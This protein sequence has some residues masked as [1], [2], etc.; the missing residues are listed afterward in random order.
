MKA[1]FR[2]AVQGCAVAL[3]FASGGLARA[4]EPPHPPNGAPAPAAAAAP[5]PPGSP[6]VLPP[7]PQPKAFA[8]VIKG[9]KELPGFFKLY[10]KDEKVWIA[11]KPEQLDKPFFFSYNIPRSIGERGLY[12]G[13]M[14][15]SQLAVFHKIGNTI[16]LIARNTEFF[17][18]EGTPQAHFV[19]ESFSDSLIASAA[20][21]SQPNPEDKSVLVEANVL[22]FADIPG[23]LTR[24]E[25]AF[26]I[27]YALDARNTSIS[28]ISNTERL[29]G[30]Q[31]DVHF[32]V[33]KLAAPPLTP[34]PVPTPP[35][36]KATP[37]PRSLF[38]SFYYNFAELPAQPMRP[39][40]AD[41]RVGYFT[42]SRV[43]FT[44]DTAVKPRVQYVNR[45]RLEKKDPAAPVS[46]PKEPIV[47]WLDRNIPAKYR[48]SVA[49]GILE[50]NK[51]FEKAGFRN[52]IVVKQQTEQD[53]FDTM[54][55]RH[56]SIR[57][58]TGADVGF[59]IGPSHV[60]PRSGEILDADIGMSD[61]FGRGARRLVVEDLGRLAMPDGND[62]YAADPLRARKG[63]LACDYGAAGAD[64]A[65]F[66]F[67]LLE[68]RGLDM[69]G[70][71]ADSLA[72]S[73]VKDVIMHEVG[74]TLGL[75][76][77][78]RASAVYS[79]KQIEDPSFSRVNGIV[80]SVMD[81]APFNISPNGEK[82]G[83]YV[84]STLGPYDYWAIEYAYRE[85]DAANE[86]AELAKMAARS[87]EP[88][89][90]FATDEDAGVGKLFIGIDPEVNR[91][92]LGSDPLEYYKRRMK[93]SRELWD[94]LQN[95]K[96][97]P[98]ES[99]ERLTRSFV[100]GFLQVARIAPLA[101]KYVGGV[102]THRDRAGTGRALFEPTPVARQRE[103]LAIINGD[104]FQTDS[105]RFQPQFLGRLAFD[106]FARP[107]NPDLS[108]SAAVFGVQKAV[109]DQL[110]S[111][112]VAARLIGAPEKAPD[113]SKVLR[114]SELYD[115]LQASIWS[116]LKSGREISSMRRNLQRE[117]LRLMTATLLHPPPTTPA[118]ARSLMRMN[119]QA[120]VAELRAA[121]SKP[122]FSKESRAHVAESLDTLQEALKAPMQRAPA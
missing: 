113:A 121:Q 28:S 5:I 3:V 35:P 61:V 77:N 85:M 43:D 69:E 84:M 10:E 65:D 42:T 98:G 13:Q 120:L 14:G 91:F 115:T 105:F 62:A 45:W 73:Y 96:L 38:V 18:K 86:P 95:L 82:Q 11:L 67:D 27:P 76:H 37:D 101:A 100:S 23:Y 54:D 78:F 50:W 92:D 34:P 63:F 31:V 119:A 75:R 66:A 16:Q 88:Q 40:I 44:D 58:F 99:Y 80:T 7:V 110:L 51:A 12:G 102:T 111:D 89:L 56:A 22:L 118:D 107:V 117:H 21:V 79:L 60:D 33:P 36:P 59:A 48:Q 9:A 112:P 24:L 106:E 90:A 72:Q 74:H 2:K 53:S 64:E 41:E 46:E 52:A 32:A 57:W 25:T 122:G 103:A 4:D 55:A 29:T 114:L 30:L 109:L 15:D 6:P 87:V 71:E 47:F 83:E 1:S 68:A 116:E 104:F 8:E 108:L 97:A 20:V 19:H 93:L 39:R 17:A 26:R 81:Y 94:R 70:P 49:D